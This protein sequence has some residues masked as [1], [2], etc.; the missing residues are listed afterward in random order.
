MRELREGPEEENNHSEVRTIG[1]EFTR[2]VLNFTD[3]DLFSFL[4]DNF[5]C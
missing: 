2:K 5:P 1:E 3:F 4:N